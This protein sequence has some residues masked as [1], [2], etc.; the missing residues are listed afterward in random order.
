MEDRRRLASL[1]ASSSRRRGRRRAGDVGLVP[2]DRGRIDVDEE[3]AVKAFRE[4][5]IARDLLPAR[6]D[7]YYTMLR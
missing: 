7:D 4:A 2:G 5:L 6:H 1:S 3:R